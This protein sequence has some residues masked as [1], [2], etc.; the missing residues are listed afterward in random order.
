MKSG[1][2]VFPV[3]RFSS[4]PALHPRFF[5]LPIN[6]R[7]VF[8]LGFVRLL[9]LGFA[10]PLTARAGA[11]FLAEGGFGIGRKPLV[12]VGTFLFGMLFWHPA[13]LMEHPA[14]ALFDCQ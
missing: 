8:R 3:F 9:A 2:N 6:G 5:L 4:P 11:V 12:T 1:E 13:F 14:P 7:P 10:H